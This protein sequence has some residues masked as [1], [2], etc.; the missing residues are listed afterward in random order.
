MTALE[1]KLNLLKKFNLMDS[2]SVED[3]GECLKDWT[4]MHNMPCL[5]Y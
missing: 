2:G 3:F 4:K 5:F 1:E